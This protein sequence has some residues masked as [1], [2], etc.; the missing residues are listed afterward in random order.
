MRNILEGA[1]MAETITLLYALAFFL[2]FGFGPTPRDHSS[3]WHFAARAAVL[4]IVFG[5]VIAAPLG[6]LLGGVAGYIAY[7]RRAK[8]VTL[9]LAG[10]AL[11][12]V[13]ALSMVHLRG[14]ELFVTSVPGIVLTT[15]AAL[16]LERR[17]RPSAAPV[18]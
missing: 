8:L 10:S 11:V 3:S 5:T 2:F 16:V 15:G 4:T 7:H 13:V 6:A 9:S 1:L 17:T 18:R 14:G 12:L